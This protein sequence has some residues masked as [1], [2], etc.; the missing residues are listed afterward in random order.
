MNKEA[1]RDAAQ[2]GKP[3][4]RTEGGAAVATWTSGGKSYVLTDMNVSEETLRR[5]I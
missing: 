3:V 5:L 1:L 4:I 2:D